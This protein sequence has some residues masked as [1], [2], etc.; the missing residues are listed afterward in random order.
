L[1]DQAA[2]G[3]TGGEA[4]APVQTASGGNRKW[5]ILGVIAI[6]QLMVVLDGT[7]VNIA[8]PDAQKALG[9]T[10]GD[11]Q[12]IITGYA[13]AFGSLLLLGG[14]LADLFGRKLTFVTGLIG[15]AAASAV[16]GAAIGFPM[17]VSA[18]VCQG[19]FG[20]LLAPAGLSLLTTTFPGKKERGT[21]FAVYGA[22][23]ASGS[24][25]GMILGGVL[26]EYLDW[27]WCL[28]INLIFAAV[29]TAGGLWLL[30]GGRPAVRPRL[31]LP[32]TV[33]VCAGLFCL[34]Y[35]FSN[36]ES[37]S[38]GALSTWGFL[39]AGAALIVVFVVR[40][41]RAANPLLPLRIVL[42][43]N[44]GGAY[45]ATFLVM[46]GVSGVFLFLTYYLQDTR[47]YS[48]VQAGL[49]YLPML[50][51]AVIMGML[52]NLVLLPR[53]GPKPL[54]ALG[55]LLA[56]GGMAWLTGIGLHTSYIAA[57][58][59]PLLLA[60]A[61][62]G[63][64]LS[65]ASNTAT[66]RVPDQD[67]GVA[68]AM[69]NTMQQIGQSIGT[70]LLNT[71]AISATTSY[72]AAHARAGLGGALEPLSLVHGYTTS[73][74]WAAGIFAAG[75]IICGTLLRRGALAGQGNSLPEDALEAPDGKMSRPGSIDAP[76]GQ[77]PRQE[78][79]HGG[80]ND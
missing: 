1:S 64:A 45:L 48:P 40:Q 41:S 18:R 29:G 11:R 51:A 74:W 62:M 63:L 54:I 36:A 37:H 66:F 16:G 73:F 77:R 24:A 34:V 32:G 9:F 58:L 12:W 8:L 61:G 42:S 25:L 10:N 31:D 68:S 21:A 35:G 7:V 57:L 6:A 27:R 79:R 30:A 22:I 17:L 72:L 43:R 70:A 20:A 53:T 75:A 14:K 59:G 28:Y 23:V 38:W 44:R 39:A 49:A 13:L 71:L 76:R 80:Y 55:M 33:A 2:V 56:A 4:D 5:L 67:S 15:F 78:A 50:L 47:G 3:A 46:A 65:P 19:V 26:T 52:S 60:G 69:V